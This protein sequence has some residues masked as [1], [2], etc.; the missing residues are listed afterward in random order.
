MGLDFIIV[1]ADGGAYG[2]RDS[3]THEFQV[4]ADLVKI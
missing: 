3:K 4:I 1:E 2:Q